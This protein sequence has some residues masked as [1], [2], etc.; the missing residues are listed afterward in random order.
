MKT[1]LR[2]MPLLAPSICYA[3]GILLGFYVPIQILIFTIIVTSVFLSL[4]FFW[5]DLFA[6]SSIVLLL[7][8]ILGISNQYYFTYSSQCPS[9]KQLSDKKIHLNGV[10]DSEIKTND[11]LPY[12][13]FIIIS[14]QLGNIRLQSTTTSKLSPSLL[15]GD[16]LRMVGTIKSIRPPSSPRQFDYKR[17]LQHKG[18][19]FGFE[20]DSIQKM[21]NSSIGLRRAA[22]VVKSDC[23][24]IME[25]HIRNVEARQIC[26][27]MVLG[28]KKTMDEDLIKSFRDTGTSHYMAVSGLHVDLVAY[29]MLVLFSTIKSHSL[30]FRLIKYICF[31]LFVWSYALLVGLSPSVM[32]AATMFSFYSFGRL[33]G[34]PTNTWNIL[35]LTA[36]ILLIYNPSF[37]FDVGF[38]LS[39]IAVISIIVYS[40]ILLKNFNAKGK[41]V[42][43]CLSAIKVT[44]AVQI[45]IFPLN[46]YYFHQFP[47]NFILANSFFWLFAL[48]LIYGSIFLI[49][50]SY[51]NTTIASITGQILGYISDI[52]QYCLELIQHFDSF[53]LKDVWLTKTE[54]LVIYLC[55]IS[56]TWCIFRI[57]KHSI[58]ALFVSLMLLGEL[59]LIRINRYQD[60]AFIYVYRTYPSYRLDLIYK[61]ECYTYSP[62]GY[63]LNRVVEN[64]RSFHAIKQIHEIDG[65]SCVEDG[66]LW[67]YKNAIGYFG[68]NILVGHTES[69]SNFCQY[70][71]IVG[72]ILNAQDSCDSEN[73][74]INTAYTEE[75]KNP[76]IHHLL[77]QGT[78]IKEINLQ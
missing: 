9:C 46:L 54:L 43:K 42:T 64:N 2:Q 44:L 53:I 29:L 41:I 40:P 24:R 4:S 5:N 50:S 23:K 35:A 61:N 65:L 39:F 17:Y 73:Q 16:H 72:D 8:I 55:I 27:A 13:Q 75:I 68:L 1:T 47:L 51:I 19:Y 31:I 36:I 20:V 32:R 12:T 22:Q 78:F 52:L 57:S 25:H 6:K 48:L 67:N 26:Q 74:I 34:L 10:L 37:L 18:I 59:C 76:H 11:S 15:I 62:M 60:V 71:I 69:I 33:F 28:E 14:P 30:G 63:S 38:Q 77:T 70:D 21:P 49:F 58:I 56:L 66:Y 7:F 3:S 45:L